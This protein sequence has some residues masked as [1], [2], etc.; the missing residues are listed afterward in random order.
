MRL[1]AESIDGVAA[2]CDALSVARATYYRRRKPRPA[3][4]PR[5]PSPRGLSPEERER[6][7]ATLH[8]ERYVDLSPATV[9]ARLL[10]ER[11]EYLCSERTMY[12]V[13]ASAGEVRERRDQLT[14]PE[15]P[16][17]ELVATAPNQVWSWDITKLLGPVKWTYFY[18][19]VVLD[20]F[21]RYVVGWMVADRENAAHARR[22]IAES[23]AKH[24]VV[25]GTLTLHQD[26]GAPMRAKTFA[27]TLADLGVTKTHSRPHVSDDNPFSEAQFK[28]LKYRPD[29][30][31][32]FGSLPDALSHCRGFF[33]WYN[34]EHRHE[35]LSLLTPADVHH[36]RVAEVLE[37]RQ[38]VLDDA[39]AAHPER[40]V[41]RPPVVAAPPREV[42]IN[43]PRAAQ[44]AAG[45]PLPAMVA[46]QPATAS[47][48]PVGP[49]RSGGGAQ[50][51][52][53]ETGVGSRRVALV[54]DPGRDPSEEALQ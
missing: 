14:H 41:R 23:C 1:I 33:D 50:R 11:G 3:L 35:A 30:P 53:A 2:A 22:L 13:L 15:Y 7:L 25:P 5:S 48:A 17:P 10:D 52:D 20:I 34:H 12:R 32:R 47:G 46:F 4:A 26:R 54:L 8:D 43:R 24:G 36:G 16:K 45:S 29:F 51:L 38:R 27:Q 31:G 9:Y 21:S 49:E 19:Y 39:Y 40:F 28:T 37:A 42:W 6:V 44:G 18:L